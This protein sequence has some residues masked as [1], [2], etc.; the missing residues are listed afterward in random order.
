MKSIKAFPAILSSLLLLS[1]LPAVTVAQ[2]TRPFPVPRP[3]SSVEGS[4]LITVNGQGT[5]ET[6]PDQATIMLGIQVTRPTAQDALDQ[7]NMVMDQIVRQIMALGIPRE[8]IHTA[9]VS[10][11][12]LR[13]PSPGIT[14]PSGYQASNNVVVTVDDLKLV[15]RAIDKAVA[16]GAN[17]V[18]GLTFGVRDSSTYRARA[19]RLAVQN[20][21]ATASA[22]ASAAG[23]SNL[24][25]VR[26]DETGQFLVPRIGIAAPMQAAPSTPIMPGTLPLTVQIQVVY[27][28]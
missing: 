3:A 11:Y 5:V 22:L 16:A 15:G 27:A 23:V 8:Q 10:L 17:S 2:G 9:N 20:A 26:I 25:V 12:F 6:T 4:R 18:E 14:E 7:A 13:R 1:L 24:R 19:L 21:H 28:F